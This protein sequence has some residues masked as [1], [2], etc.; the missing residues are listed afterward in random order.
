MKIVTA[1]RLSDGRVIYLGEASAVV[2]DLAS[3]ALF[4]G[5]AADAALIAAASQP[6]TW[7]NPYLVEVTGHTPSG[8]DRLKETI[9]SAGPTVGNSLNHR[10][11]A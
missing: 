9:R 10:E 4:E 7:V 1:N 8:R 5:D 11:P 3:A 6:A 2:E